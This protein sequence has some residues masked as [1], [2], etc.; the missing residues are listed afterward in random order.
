MTAD[1]FRALALSFPEAAEGSHFDTADFRVGKKIFATLRESDRRAVLKL[2]PDEQQLLM[3]TGR[4]I[5]VPIKGSWGLKG[6]THII[7]E[8]ADAET[9]RHAM[10]FAWKSVAPKKLVKAQL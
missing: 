7:L 6:W 9:V 4:G 8:Q 10:A 3:E 5:F 2:S 1:E